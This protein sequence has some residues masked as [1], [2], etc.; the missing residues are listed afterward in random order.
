MSLKFYD[1]GAQTC[2]GTLELLLLVNGQALFAR[3]LLASPVEFLDFSETI[4]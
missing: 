2:H 3:L 4:N 1:M